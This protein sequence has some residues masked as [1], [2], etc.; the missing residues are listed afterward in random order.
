VP[1]RFYR[2]NTPGEE[3]YRNLVLNCIR[4][5]EL[6][7]GFLRAIYLP[8]TASSRTIG[9]MIFAIYR[10]SVYTAARASANFDSTSGKDPVTRRRG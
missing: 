5:Q 8:M 2:G 7:C 10:S 1:Y 9:K 6:L 4:K 3:S